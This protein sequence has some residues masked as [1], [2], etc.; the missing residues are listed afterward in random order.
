MNSQ[1]NTQPVKP[2]Q[3]LEALIG[4]RIR[5]NRSEEGI[6]KSVTG[7]FIVLEKEGGKQVIIARR[8]IS[9]IE[10]VE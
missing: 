7:E 6:L 3:I 8:S 10:V 5:V 2:K 1:T 4:K 9:R